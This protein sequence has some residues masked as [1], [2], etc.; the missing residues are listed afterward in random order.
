MTDSPLRVERFT[1]ERLDP[2]DIPSVEP[3]WR[4]LYRHHAAVAPDL[5]SMAERVSADVS[6]TRRRAYYQRVSS[7]PGS[8]CL[9]GRSA[10]RPVAYAFAHVRVVEE[11]TWTFDDRIAV[12]DTLVV[13][14]QVRGLGVGS[15]LLSAMKRELAGDGV[16]TM[17]VPV[18]ATNADALRFYEREG[19]QPFLL[20]LVGPTA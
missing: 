16:G 2:D 3:L 15:A 11:G 5:N 8:V 19:L 18:I 1:V 20:T 17:E 4:S 14:P 7:E 9:L 12:L 10:G 6:W 13:L